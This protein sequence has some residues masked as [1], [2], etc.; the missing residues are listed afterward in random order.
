MLFWLKENDCG[1][2]W[3]ELE[4]ERGRGPHDMERERKPSTQG[5]QHVAASLE[6][7]FHR[8]EALQ[9]PDNL[10]K[11]KSSSLSPTL[12]RRPP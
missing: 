5:K 6:G 12:F 4:R 10:Q 2:G 3:G 8:T 1:A 7:P 9:I 11:E